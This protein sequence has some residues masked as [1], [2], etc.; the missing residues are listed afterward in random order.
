MSFKAPNNK[1]ALP[2][3][4]GEQTI[5]DSLE[6]PVS[7]SQNINSYSQLYIQNKSAGDTASADLVLG[8]DNDTPGLD[9]RY[10]N[11]G[12]TGSGFSGVSAALGI[13]KSV[14]VTVGGTGYTVGD[15]LNLATGDANAMVQVLT[16]PGGVVGTV[17]L[18]DNGTNYTTGTKATTG[19]TGTG[20]TINVLTLFDFTAQLANSTYLFSVGGDLL[21]GTDD[22]VANKVVK[23]CV[24][25]TATA[26]IRSTMSSTEFTTTL[27][28][29]LLSG[30]AVPAGGATGSGLKLSSTTNLGIFFGSGVPTLSAAQGSL[31]IRTDGSST[32]T[33]MYVNTNGTTGWTAVTTAS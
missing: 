26:N 29:T 22:T 7:I 13:I 23:F 31:Y 16:A 33:R 19:G 21:V 11:L 3:V 2:V 28:F 27:P 32:S 17:S 20:C 1:I 18:V 4:I 15:Q 6:T 10:A 12:Y 24:G 5:Q 25:G 14:S 8:A 9:G 30:T